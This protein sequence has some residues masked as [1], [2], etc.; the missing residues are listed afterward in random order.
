[1]KAL[2]EHLLVRRAAMQQ[3]MLSDCD[4]VILIILNNL[5]P[6][7]E[8]FAALLPTAPGYSWTGSFQWQKANAGEAKRAIFGRV[9]APHGQFGISIQ[10]HLLDVAHVPSMVTARIMSG[11]QARPLVAAFLSSTSMC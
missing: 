8:K 1:M 7:A 4:T 11:D 3:S 2:R 10:K 5:F 6:H 9:S